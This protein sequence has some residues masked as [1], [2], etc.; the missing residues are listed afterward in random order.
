MHMRDYAFGL[1]KLVCLTRGLTEFVGIA[2]LKEP[3]WIGQLVKYQEESYI[4][5]HCRGIPVDDCC[6]TTRSID[7]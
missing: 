5:N 3:E 6:A 7:L 1:W 2:L 4:P